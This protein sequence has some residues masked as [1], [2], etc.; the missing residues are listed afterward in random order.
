MRKVSRFTFNDFPV[1]QKT[2]FPNRVRTVSLFNSEGYVIGIR[3]LPHGKDMELLV[4]PTFNSHDLKQ[5]YI[6]YY[7]N[8]KDQTIV[9]LMPGEYFEVE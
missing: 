5:G 6:G 9:V 2:K 3:A 7:E 8:K 4:N 1:E